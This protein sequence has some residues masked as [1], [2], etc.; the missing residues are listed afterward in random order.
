M[1]KSMW[2]G[3]E[4]KWKKIS[5]NGFPT[6]EFSARFVGNSRNRGN[7]A[8]R[9]DKTEFSALASFSFSIAFAFSGKDF[10]RQKN[11]SVEKR[12]RKSHSH[13]IFLWKILQLFLRKFWFNYEIF[14]EAWNHFPGNCENEKMGKLENLEKW[15]KSF[16]LMKW[17]QFWAMSEFYP[18]SGG[19]ND[20]SFPPDK[21]Q[22][23]FI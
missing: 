2:N 14:M 23:P 19:K 15:V 12:E 22:F 18:M 20:D 6:Q 13:L 21:Q 9:R 10:S 11:K 16:Q 4:R 7:R 17:R 5:F 8:E 3:K 1:E